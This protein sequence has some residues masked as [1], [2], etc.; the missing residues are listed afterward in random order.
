MSVTYLKNNRSTRQRILPD[1]ISSEI[2]AQTAQ[3]LVYRPGVTSSG[4]AFATWAE[5]MTAL[6]ATTAPEGVRV[7]EFDDRIAPCTIP[8]TITPYDMTDVVWAGKRGEPFVRTATILEGASFTNLTHITDGLSVFSTATT[9]PIV[10]TAGAPLRLLLSNGANIAT[11]SGTNLISLTSGSAHIITL[12]ESASILNSAPGGTI[13][14]SGGAEAILRIGENCLVQEQ[15]FGGGAGEFLYPQGLSTSMRWEAQILFGGTIIWFDGFIPASATYEDASA[16]YDAAYGDSG[17]RNVGP[18]IGPGVVSNNAGPG[19]LGVLG[20][21]KERVYFNGGSAFAIVM[22]FPVSPPNEGR[23]AVKESDGSTTA[24]I[25]LDGKGKTFEDPTSLGSFVP[26][27]VMTGLF[28]AGFGAT[29]E[30]NSSEDRWH[31]LKLV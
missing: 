25:T 20:T 9:P 10:G 17:G 16:T 13:G 12:Q 15:A 28:S 27:K 4:N 1:S 22:E 26:I 11:G 14:M 23:W 3:R 31:L 6:G 30:F 29:W 5:I 2:L 18:W 19:A 8:S 21:L 24:T 7:I